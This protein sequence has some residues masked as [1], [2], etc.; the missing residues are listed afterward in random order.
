MARQ[1]IGRRERAGLKAPRRG[2][3]DTSLDVSTNTVTREYTKTVE[4]IDQYAT[5]TFK[6][7]EDFASLF[8][9]EPS[10]PE[11]EKPRTP[12]KE[13]RDEI[14]DLVFKEQIKQY[15][16]R[17]SALKGN[18][19]AIWSV[20]IGQCTGETMKAKLLSIKEYGMRHKEGDCY[21]LLKS[22]L[23]ITL[24]FDKRRNGYLAIAMDAYQ[25]F[26]TCKQTATLTV[27]EHKQQLTL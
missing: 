13:G 20:A 19:A 24:Q 25:N 26:L 9:A 21:W 7:P 8:T 3:T 4:A 23:L 18:L 2:W 14:D 1:R 15:V 11:I 27:E 6:F 12:P 10:T 22:I 16:T 5:K 17:C